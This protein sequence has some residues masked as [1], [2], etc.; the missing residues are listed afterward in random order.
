MMEQFRSRRSSC[1]WFWW[2]WRARRGNA[3]GATFGTSPQPEPLYSG[4]GG[5]AVMA[6]GVPELLEEL[7]DQVAV[8]VTEWCR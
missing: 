3:G 4:G 7:E 5:G 2:F 8:V 1:N 6:G